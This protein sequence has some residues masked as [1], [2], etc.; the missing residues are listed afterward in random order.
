MVLTRAQCRAAEFG[1]PGEAVPGAVT[2]VTARIS[3]QALGGASKATAASGSTDGGL[4]AAANWTSLVVF[5]FAASL[6]FASLSHAAFRLAS[7]AS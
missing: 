4:A 7:V 3:L 1:G 5:V 2:A 6:I